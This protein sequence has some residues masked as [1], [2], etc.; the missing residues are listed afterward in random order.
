MST[1]AKCGDDCARCVPVLG[2]TDKQHHM[3]ESAIG[4]SKR[5]LVVPGVP[6]PT[7][8]CCVA[9]TGNGCFSSNTRV[10]IQESPVPVAIRD[11]EVGQHLLCFDG[12]DDMLAPGVARWCEVKN[13]VSRLCVRPHS[14]GHKSDPHSQGMNLACLAMFL[15]RSNS[16][17]SNS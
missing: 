12:G 7:G 1:T 9:G 16:L 10:V 8:V 15:C 5:I 13:F 4:A 2:S 3:S 11:V 17:P 14:Q 6:Q